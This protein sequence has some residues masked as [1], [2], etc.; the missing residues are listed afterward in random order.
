MQ[1]RSND[2]GANLVRHTRWNY[3]YLQMSILIKNFHIPK[4]N[5]FK[6]GLT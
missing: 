2:T 6:H 1:D 4:S 3:M 5:E